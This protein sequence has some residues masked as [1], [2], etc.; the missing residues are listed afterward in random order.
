MK[1]RKLQISILILL[2]ILVVA[3]WYFFLKKWDYKVMFTAPV[4]S[5]VAYSFIKNYNEWDG[6]TLNPGQLVLSNPEPWTQL[7][8]ELQLNDE[9][10]D[11]DW[12]LKQKNDSV[13][14][15]V[16]ECSNPDRALKNRLDILLRRSA[17]AKS[18]KRNVKIIRDKLK[19]RSKEFHY[20]ITNDRSI[21]EIACVA[22]STQSTIRG[23][24]DEMIRNVVDLNMFVK[25]NNLGLNGDPMIVIHKW[26]PQTD[27]IDFDFCFPVVHP[28]RMPDDPRIK[29]EKVAVPKAL[30]AEYFGNYCYS[31][32]AWGALYEKIR[33]EEFET[34]GRIIEV[35]YNDP[36]TG[37]DDKDWK[38]GIYMELKK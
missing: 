23:K 11:F 28:E 34:T 26:D 16:V 24:A 30:Y 35:F 31:D 37:E 7:S 27:V 19:K 36:H 5:S 32:Y 17:Y 14:K 25:D 33:K 15:V 12:Y 10:W 2:L 4:H 3:A 22:I 18:V 8:A 29:L 21:A 38:A 13:T 9:K 6:K 20:S 1:R